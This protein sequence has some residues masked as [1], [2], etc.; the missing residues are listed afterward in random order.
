M[1]SQAYR[2]NSD[3][4]KPDVSAGRLLSGSG[5]R[6]IALL[7]GMGISFFMMPFLIRSLGDHWYGLW[8]L[9]ASTLGF[10]G[11]FDMGLASATQRYI[12]HALATDDHDRL[13]TILSNSLFIYCIIAAFAVV[14]T[15]IIFFCAPVFFDSSEDTQTF[16]FI[17]LV[18]GCTFAIHFVMNAYYGILSAYLRFDIQAIV[19][20]TKTVLRASCIYL[21]FQ[22]DPSVINLALI[23]VLFDLV[24][25][26]LIL[27]AAQRE[28]NWISPSLALVSKDGIRELMGF[29]INSFIM[30]IGQQTRDRGPHFAIASILSIAS[31]TLFQ[32]ASQLIQYLNQLQSSLLGVLMPSFTRLFGEGKNEELSKNYLFSL[33]LSALTA[34]CLCGGIISLGQPFITFWIGPGY[35]EAY[36]AVAAMALGYF[37]VLIHYPS[38]QLLVA[39]AEHKTFARFEVIEGSLLVAIAAISGYYYGVAGVGFGI[40]LLLS[41]SRFVIMPILLKQAWTHLNVNLYAMTLGL[42]AIAVLVH[43]PIYILMNYLSDH[44]GFLV[45]LSLS[46]PVYLLATIIFVLMSLSQDEQSTIK[47]L[48]ISTVSRSEEKRNESGS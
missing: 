10:Y 30:F 3:P 27:K 13:N 14:A 29:G 37:F 39:L 21:I 40:A 33:K 24:A 9:V 1:R 41:I 8:I 42:L 47:N 19:D 46:I 16:Q 23:T 17:I 48:I 5:L 34:S 26:Y 22:L 15:V 20:I 7:T 44:H 38:F 4:G 43:Y 6:T 12:S 31:V 28:A 18:M 32:I 45:L 35:E 25:Q 36:Y 2:R 11:V